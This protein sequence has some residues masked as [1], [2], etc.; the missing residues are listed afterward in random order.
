MNRSIIYVMSVLIDNI[1]EAALALPSESRARLANRLL[2]S[3]D[4]E[5]ESSELRESRIAE[6]RRRV[7][8]IK[9]GTVEL[10]DA[11]TAFKRIDKLLAR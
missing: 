6:L 3:L 7:S 11:D 9:S 2:D 1:E 5:A 10:I 4:I 8:E